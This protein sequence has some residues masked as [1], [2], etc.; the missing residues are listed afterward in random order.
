MRQFTRYRTPRD[1]TAAELDDI[2]DDACDRWCS[3]RPHRLPVFQWI[4]TYN[5]V[6]DSAVAT[7][8]LHNYICGTTPPLKLRRRRVDAMVAPCGVVFFPFP[9][10]E[11]AR[12]IRLGDIQS[13]TNIRCNAVVSLTGRPA[14][15]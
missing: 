7:L 4:L 13:L 6:N 14:N 8:V 3:S 2:V 5:S 1:A 9:L 11:N 15:Q 12:N 10:H